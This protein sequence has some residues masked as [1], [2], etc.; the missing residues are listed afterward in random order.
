M[1]Q[2]VTGLGHIALGRFDVMY[3]HLTFRA[4]GSYVAAPKKCRK[5]VNDDIC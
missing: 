2:N 3:R 1:P 5:A 4:V